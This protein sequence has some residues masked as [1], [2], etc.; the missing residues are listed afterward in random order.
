MCIITCI[1]INE[2]AEKIKNLG[3]GIKMGRSKVCI[4]LFADDIVIIAESKEELQ[5]MMN[6]TFELSRK[7]RFNFNFDKCAVMILSIWAVQ[8]RMQMWQTLEIW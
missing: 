1:F 3:K 7:W 6:A 2:L 8:R 4:L 5:M